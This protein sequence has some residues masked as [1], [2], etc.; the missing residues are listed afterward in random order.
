MDFFLTG[1]G[2]PSCGTLFDAE[3][4]LWLSGIALVGIILCMIHRRLSDK[5]R[6]NFRRVVGLTMF[7]VYLLRQL[8]IIALGKYGVWCL[9]LH[10]CG[11]S[12]YIE[13]LDCLFPNRFTN[14]LCYAVCM[15]GALMGAVYANWV[16]MPTFNFIYIT[17]FVL[18]GLMVIYPFLGLTSGDFRPSVRRL[19]LCFAFL[20]VVSVPVYFFNMRFGTNFMFLAKPSPGSPLVMFEQWFGNPGYLLGFVIMIAVVWAVM[21]VPFV[22]LQARNK[23]KT[24]ED[25]ASL[26]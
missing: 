18:H 16:H 24:A 23:T 6:V 12:L 22:I 15:P 10:L 9:P 13:A 21:Y 26:V 17:G 5:G 19:P 1:Y 4:I 8:T 7:G 3:H 25:T 2:G 20:A 11:M 14:E